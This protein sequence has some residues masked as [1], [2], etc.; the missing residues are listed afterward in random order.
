MT[1]HEKMDVKGK[2]LYLTT[3]SALVNPFK[4]GSKITKIAP[5]LISILKTNYLSVQISGQNPTYIHIR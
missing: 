2:D 3:N 4:M 1:A 5:L